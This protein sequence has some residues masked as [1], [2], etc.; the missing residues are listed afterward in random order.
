MARS[1]HGVPSDEGTHETR[2]LILQVAQRLF[3]E[4]GYRTVSTRHIAA[5]CGITQP[6]LYRHF[7][8]K[9]DLYVA[10][11]LEMLSLLHGRIMHLAER[12]ESVPVRLHLIARV[13]PATWMDARQMFHDIEHE[14][15][16]QHRQITA[17]AF[18]QQI[19][20]PI[21]ALFT[22]GITQG[23]L[24]DSEQ[25]GLAPQEATFVLLRLLDD[26]NT[27]GLQEHSHLQHA[28]HMVDVLLHGLLK[29][30]DAA[31]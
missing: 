26:Q 6:A 27:P 25:G 22:E 28:D 4:Q 23:L 3:M 29:Q 5:A 30:V 2:K 21:A 14:L 10:V 16:A 13:L 12:K 17:D 24:R 1:S 8:T 19:I 18:R 20:E 15:D 31:E 11:L 7:A 9:Q